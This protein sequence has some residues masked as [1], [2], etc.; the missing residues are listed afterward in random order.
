MN[1]TSLNLTHDQA[2]SILRRT[3]AKVR[4]LIFRDV[5]LQLS[6]LDP[7]QIYNI[8]EVEL[9]KK[10]GRGLGISIVGRKDEPGVYISEVVKGGVAEQDGRLL[11]GDQILNVC[12]QDV[13]AKLQEDV[14]TLLKVCFLRI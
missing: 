6:L 2:I 9:Q 4:L 8:H 10:P 13:S 12:G 14:A 7:T 1:G 5:N 3:P 11:Q